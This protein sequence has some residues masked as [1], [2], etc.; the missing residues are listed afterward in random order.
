MPDQA[1]RELQAI[2]DLRAR[3]EREL[4]TMRKGTCVLLDTAKGIKWLDISSSRLAAD[5]KNLV[6]ELAA[7]KGTLHK[8]GQWRE[9][10]AY[11][12][13]LMVCCPKCE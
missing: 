7:V 4:D 13:L 5:A 10:Q 12:T 3:A 1:L 8:D 9:P 6:R 11:T 2:I